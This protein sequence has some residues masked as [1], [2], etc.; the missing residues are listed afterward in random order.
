MDLSFFFFIFGTYVMVFAEEPRLCTVEGCNLQNPG[1]SDNF[2]IY[3]SAH[4]LK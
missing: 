1:S 3:L 2:I 4:S